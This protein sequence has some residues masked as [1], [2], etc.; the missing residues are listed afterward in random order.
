MTNKELN[1]FIYNYIKEKNDEY[2]KVLG[3]CP[4]EYKTD[5]SQFE[6]FFF[7]KRVFNSNYDNLD[8]F[9]KIVEMKI[10]T[11]IDNIKNLETHIKSKETNE[12]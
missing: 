3:I 11:T 10:E 7:G 2:I 8:W 4:F 6:V 1:S 9:E 12:N 5:G